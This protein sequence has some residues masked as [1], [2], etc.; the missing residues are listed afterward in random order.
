MSSAAPQPQA[1]P[2]GI[3]GLL[4][5]DPVQRIV[6]GF[7]QLTQQR[8]P[9]LLALYSA[10][11]RFKDPLND[12]VGRDRIE[13]VYRHMFDALELPRFVVTGRVVAPGQ[14]V[15]TWEFHFGFKRFQGGRRHSV[16]GASHLLLTDQG[17]ICLHR[18][19]WD[20][21][22]EIY[23]KLPL[24]GPLMRWLKRRAAT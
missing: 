8:L 19:Y 14:C 13:R 22:E 5:P 20:P 10:D 1:P 23:E 12:V 11:A 18:D 17:Q 2:G 3:Q 9:E 4:L 16:R 7:E 6:A 21:A 15:L 24:L